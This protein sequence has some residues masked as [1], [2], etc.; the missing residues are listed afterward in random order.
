MLFAKSG[1]TLI[2]ALLVFFL[3]SPIVAQTGLSADGQTDTYTLI[4]NV[5]APGKGNT[6]YEVPDQCDP[7]NAPHIRQIFDADRGHY[8]FQFLIHLISVDPV[9]GP[10]DCDPATGDTDRQRNEI[11]TYDPSPD[12]LKAN[13]GDTVTYRWKFKLDSA[14][15]CSKDFTHIHQIKAVNGNDST[16]VVTFTCEISGTT[17]QFQLRFVNDAGT[18]TYW[19]RLTLSTSGLLGQWV[20]A[21]EKITFNSVIGSAT[22][23]Y[24]MTLTRVSD[25]KN[26]LSVTEN[27]LDLL[28]SNPNPSNPTFYRP[29]WGIYRSVASYTYLRD[30][31]VLFDHFCLAK[32]SDDCPAVTDA[33]DFGVSATPSSGIATAGGNATFSTTITPGNGFNGAVALTATGLPSG[34]S[35]SF[36]PASV[37]GSGSSRLTI[38]TTSSTPPGTYPVII[39]ATSGAVA[40][41][42]NVALTVNPPLDFAFSL[43]PA[44]QTVAAGSNATYTATVAPVNGFAGSVALVAS[45]LPNGATA[46]FSPATIDGGAGSSTLSVSTASTTPPGTYAVAITAT[47]G[48]LAHSG[49]V[50]LTVNAPP[51]FAISTTPS[52]QSVP[53]GN[54]TSFTTTVVPSHGFAGSVSLTATG[55]PNAATASFN[56]ATISGG[57]GASTLTIATDRTTAVGGYTVAVSAASGDVTHNA[58]ATLVVTAAPPAPAADFAFTLTPLSPT[59]AAGGSASYTASVTPS[60]GFADTVSFSCSGLPSGAECSAPPVT[61]ANGQSATTSLTIATTGRA[62]ASNRR[63]GLP[64]IFAL[65]MPG[66]PL[67][68]TGPGWKGRGFWLTLAL[69]A[70]LALSL[71]GCGGGGSPQG[72]VNGQRGTPAGT[73]TVVVTAAAGAVQHSSSVTLTVQ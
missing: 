27:G 36:S 65:L 10:I 26:L 2:C 33:P 6:P 7:T 64:L 66:L 31:A 30:E 38:S 18:I 4:T 43:A 9:T 61:P 17:P 55:L 68:L 16:P 11:K 56:P 60:N 20:E 71:T 46:S 45:G 24:N 25:G 14:F 22:G 53:A 42:S 3:C 32:G 8:I 13:P 39:G 63:F 48:S 67:L 47:S 34:A 58:A 37:S 59:V 40:H 5:L 23:S 35:A 52:S 29:K 72:S 1:R 57:S 69:G 50:S 28:R 21:Y 44:S 19:S 62:V 51:D 70:V 49:N 73:Y 15:Q 41:S 12:Y 54:S